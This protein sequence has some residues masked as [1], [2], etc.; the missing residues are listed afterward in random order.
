MNNWKWQKKRKK[1]TYSAPFLSRFSISSIFS[2]LPLCEQKRVDGFVK[3]IRLTDNQLNNITGV[4]HIFPRESNRPC[5][6]CSA[7]LTLNPQQKWKKSK[8]KQS[9]QKTNNWTSVLQLMFHKSSCPGLLRIYTRIKQLPFLQGVLLLPAF[10]AVPKTNM[11]KR[12]SQL[13][14]YSTVKTT[15]VGQSASYFTTN[16]KT[17]Q[18][19]KLGTI[20]NLINIKQNYKS[21]NG[22]KTK[23]RYSSLFILIRNEKQDGN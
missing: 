6:S 13:Y 14:L 19:T 23:L 12:S 3:M 21:G 15:S 10:L 20:N 4:T 7:S 22:Q 9:N 16:K 11:S 5:R 1:Q 8:N 17:K 2:R 18:N